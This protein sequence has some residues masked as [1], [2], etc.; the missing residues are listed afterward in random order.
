MVLFLVPLLLIAT[1]CGSGLQPESQS[2]SAKAPLASDL[3]LAAEV[4]RTV[5]RHQAVDQAVAV[6]LKQ[7]ISVAIKVTGFDRLRLKQIKRSK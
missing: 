5:E 7:D 6:V 4:K 3:D 1:A 2:P